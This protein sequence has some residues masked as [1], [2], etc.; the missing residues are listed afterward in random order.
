M[1]EYGTR[2]DQPVRFALP[3]SD[4]RHERETRRIE[5]VPTLLFIFALVS[6]NAQCV[7]FASSCPS[8]TDTCLVF[9][10]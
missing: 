2:P 3:T 5:D 7:C 1:R 8:S 6:M 4:G 10:L 9:V